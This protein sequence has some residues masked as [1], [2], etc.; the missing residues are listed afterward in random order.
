MM[1]VQIFSDQAFIALRK[2]IELV[3]SIQLAV[4]GVQLPR[5]LN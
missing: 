3:I 1:L 5:D 2:Y 4:N